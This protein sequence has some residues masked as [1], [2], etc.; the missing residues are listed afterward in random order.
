MADAS[1]L[2]RGM[3]LL[4]GDDPRALNIEKFSKILEAKVLEE[5]PMTAY[6]MRE[7]AVETH[8]HTF[9]AVGEVDVTSHTPGTEIEAQIRP[10]RDARYVEADTKDMAAAVEEPGIDE[11]LSHLPTMLRVATNM[12]HAFRVKIEQRVIAKAIQGARRLPISSVEDG[13]QTFDGG[14]LVRINGSDI[15]TAIP[16]STAGSKKVQEAL[17]KMHQNMQE[18]NL[19]RG[20]DTM[21]AGVGPYIWRVLQQDK[22]IYNT[23]LR[24]PLGNRGLSYEVMELAGWKIVRNN[25]L[26]KTSAKSAIPSSGNF[27]IPGESTYTTNATATA[28]VCLGHAE[29]VALVEWG[30]FA[31]EAFRRRERNTSRIQALQLVGVNYLEPAGCGE[32]YVATSDYTANES[33]GTYE[34]A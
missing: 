27:T 3:A 2:N 26:N 30:G 9:Y 33:A 8:K 25:L 24:A 17:E 1:V 29:S 10:I 19:A 23:M 20:G 28:I 12:S 31:I 32:I 11:K 14:N 15:E 13:R 34:P 18:K 16:A 7:R 21:V 6:A 22:S 5:L 4:G